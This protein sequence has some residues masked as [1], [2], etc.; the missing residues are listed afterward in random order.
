M[1][2]TTTNVANDKPRMN[3][4]HIHPPRLQS[5]RVQGCAAAPPGCPL[6]LN[7]AISTSTRFMEVK[8]AVYT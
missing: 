4:L 2:I 8:K 6:N 1:P 3:L 7:K 5:A